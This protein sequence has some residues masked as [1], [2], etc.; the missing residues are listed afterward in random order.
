MILR[1]RYVKYLLQC[2]FLF[3]RTLP[4]TLLLPSLLHAVFVNNV[5]L[6]QSLRCQQRYR[7]RCG[8]LSRRKMSEMVIISNSSQKNSQTLVFSVQ[9][10][11]IVPSQLA[12]QQLT[13]CND[14]GS[15][16]FAYN[17]EVYANLIQ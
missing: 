8:E 9:Q 6:E 15:G 5:I 13:E 17:I 10:I 3:F 7:C 12:V 1:H 2:S 4:S 16:Y 14:A 11:Y